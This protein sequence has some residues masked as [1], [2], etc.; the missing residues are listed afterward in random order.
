MGSGLFWWL[1]CMGLAALITA[2]VSRRWV[3]RAALLYLVS[4]LVLFTG[5]ALWALVTR[6][7]REGVLGLILVSLG[8]V[9]AMA[10]LPWILTC[11]IGFALGLVPRR[12][13]RPADKTAP[14]NNWRPIHVGAENDALVIGG[15]PVWQAPWRPTGLAP[16]PLPHPAHPRQTHEFS[17]Y[18]IGAGA[19][20]TRFAAAELSAGVWGFYQPMATPTMTAVEV[21]TATRRPVAWRSLVAV[22]LGA[23]IAIAAGSYLAE[24]FAPSLVPLTPMPRMPGEKS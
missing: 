17:V 15:L 12:W 4:P 7:E 20:R 5:Y 6:P 19:V 21:G 11:L 8:L 3:W 23:A 16:V 1:V 9:S 22:S 10:T 18:E 2:A 13:L 24:R 14:F